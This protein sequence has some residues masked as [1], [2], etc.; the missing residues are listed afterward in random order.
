M[1]VEKLKHLQLIR[2]QHETLNN[3]NNNNNNNNKRNL[4]TIIDTD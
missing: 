3:N 1:I 2:N 4:F